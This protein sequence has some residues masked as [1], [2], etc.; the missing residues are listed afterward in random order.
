MQRVELAANGLDHTAVVMANRDDIDTRKG[1]EVAL[2][3][4]VPVMDAIGTGHDER[5]LRPLGHLVAD[6]DLAEET[7]LGGLGVG[8]QIGQSSGT[9]H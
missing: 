1:V 8:D 4:D 2:P 9:R 6:E 7:L 3:A 5:G